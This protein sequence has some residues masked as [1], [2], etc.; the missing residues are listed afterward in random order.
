MAIGKKSDFDSGLFLGIV[1]L[2]AVPLM[3]ALQA[4][5]VV[6]I[7]WKFSLGIYALVTAFFVW[8]YAKW[9][10]PDSW[11]RSIQWAIGS[12]LIIAL[13]GVSTLGI[14]KQY[15][16]DHRG[17]LEIEGSIM[18]WGPASDFLIQS[19]PVVITGTPRSEATINGSLLLDF[20]DDYR[21]VVGISKNDG[22]QDSLDR[23]LAT[24]APY[25]IREGPIPTSI[26]WDQDFIAKLLKGWTGTGYTLFAC[27]NAINPSQ[28]S[29][30]R[31]ALS[32]GCKKLKG[33][34]G[35]P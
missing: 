31:Q 30:I 19:N 23:H 3:Y 21:I 18:E 15:A 10:K 12:V 9:N 26:Y 33:V 2:L 16:K 11:R 24:S 35:P 25:A 5:G 17:V 13:V 4:N 34:S 1:G 28:F 7:G 32:M 8:A 20:A 29:T 22:T 27:P 14:V 6:E